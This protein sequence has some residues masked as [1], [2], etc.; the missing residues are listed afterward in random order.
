[1]QT[2][3]RNQMAVKKRNIQRKASPAA[4]TAR[5]PD[6]R[7][8][9]SQDH[10]KTKMMPELSSGMKEISDLFKDLHFQK[11]ILGGVDEMDVW[12]QLREV[13][14]E[15]ETLLRI[16]DEQNKALLEER[17]AEIRRL[18]RRLLE[19]TEVRGETVE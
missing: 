19:K 4:P 11:K 13:Q 17:D 3:E 14:K 15:Y 12:R 10:E 2:A 1:M 8:K 9:K 6:R 5:S 7:K 16:H 18:K